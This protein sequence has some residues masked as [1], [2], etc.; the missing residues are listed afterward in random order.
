MSKYSF[1]A[2][3]Q[4]EA[5][6]I[7][8][9]VL[10]YDPIGNSN[11]P[12]CKRED[13]REIDTDLL[14]EDDVS[15]VADMHQLATRDPN[16]KWGGNDFKY[17][18]IQLERHRR[19]HILKVFESLEADDS[20]PDELSPTVKYVSWLLKA[21]FD[22][23]R[24]ND[25]P[26]VRIKALIAM[27]KTIPVRATLRGEMNSDHKRLPETLDVEAILTP[28]QRRKVLDAEARKLGLKLIG[29]QHVEAFG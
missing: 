1:T 24:L 16:A 18:C 13:R 27:G 26:N 11:C 9:V 10:Q 15:S 28:E 29:D 22:E 4:E 7:A 14:S 19:H 23:Y 21:L 5:A 17:V 3:S 2:V 25:D 8:S 20:F 6:K 12:W